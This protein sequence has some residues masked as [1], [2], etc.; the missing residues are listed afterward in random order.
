MKLSMYQASIPVL[1]RALRNLDGVLQLAAAHAARRQIDPAVLIDGRLYP[2]MYP[3]S[4]QVQIASDTAKGC[5]ARLAGVE[6][7]S[8]A[9]DEKTFPELAA[10][11][12]KTVAYLEGFRP[13]QIDGAEGRPVVLAVRERRLSFSGADYLLQ[14]VLPSFFFHAATAYAILR[15]YG[16]ELGKND[17]MGRFD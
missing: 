1:V 13:E 15:H 17:F 8:Y 4:R 7:P 2:D 9:D 3:L 10:R 12:A 16:V 14:W 6:P 11:I 5:A